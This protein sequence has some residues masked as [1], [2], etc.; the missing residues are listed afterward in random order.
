MTL[1]TEKQAILEALLKIR[2]DGPEFKSVGI[3]GNLVLEEQFSLEIQEDWLEEQFLSWP[4]FSGDINFPVPDD[5]FGAAD[6]YF[7]S[8]EMWD[9]SSYG[10]AR[11]RLL[12]FLISTLV[13]EDRKP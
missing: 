4:E 11:W 3:C 12:D 2:D 13:E 5:S 1:N 8:A 6:A 10:Q 9:D 7:S